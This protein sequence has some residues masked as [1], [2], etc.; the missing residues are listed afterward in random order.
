[1]KT[2]FVVL[3]ATFAIAVNARAQSGSLSSKPPWVDTTG[4]SGF[5]PIGDAVYVYRAA[6]DLLYNDADRRPSVIV[7]HDTAELAGDGPCPVACNRPWPHK[8]R[9]DTTT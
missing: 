6:L 7:M 3:T 2:L 5:Y 9:I 8:S 4:E 1:M